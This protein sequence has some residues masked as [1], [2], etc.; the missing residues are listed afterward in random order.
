MVME[1]DLWSRVQ[2]RAIVFQNNL[3]KGHRVVIEK[4]QFVKTDFLV[5]K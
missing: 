2:I 5:N 4:F 3:T 1:G